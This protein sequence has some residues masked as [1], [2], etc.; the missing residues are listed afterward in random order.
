[1]TA[2]QH[3]TVRV[4][5]ILSTNGVKS[6]EIAQLRAAPRIF[7]RP[8]RAAPTTKK[9]IPLGNALGDL[10]DPEIR[11]EPRDLAQKV[12][13]PALGERPGLV[14]LVDDHHDLADAPAPHP[15]L[16]RKHV[17][18]LREIGRRHVDLK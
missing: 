16:M 1:V 6:H 15:D 17:C 14:E 11:H 8:R 7:D 13:E 12:V 3:V 4:Q 2:E 18:D 10:H 5:D 9:R